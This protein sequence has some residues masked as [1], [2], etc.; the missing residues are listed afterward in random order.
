MWNFILGLFIGATIGFFV[1]AL[2]NMASKNDNY[3]NI[4]KN[5][6]IE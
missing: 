3:G 1:A 2:C 4:K 6:D 5:G